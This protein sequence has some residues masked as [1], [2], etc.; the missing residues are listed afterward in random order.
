MNLARGV[1]VPVSA[2]AVGPLLEL[3]PVQCVILGHPD[4]LFMALA[5]TPMNKGGESIHH[6]ERWCDHA[7]GPKWGVNGLQ[8][9][10]IH[11]LCSETKG[12]GWELQQPQRVWMGKE[13][14]GF[15]GLKSKPGNN[16][17]K[18]PGID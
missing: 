18:L 3:S 11:N 6:A 12:A 14:L 9:S 17:A 15:S 7:K 2:V 1:V 13:S 5:I 16:F 4:S 10:C 8:S